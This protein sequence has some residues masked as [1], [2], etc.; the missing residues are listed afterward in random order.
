MGDIC[1]TAMCVLPILWIEHAFVALWSFSAIFFAMVLS[2]CWFL[3]YNRF[4]N[5]KI[6][7]KW[8]HLCEFLLHFFNNILYW[9][10]K[11]TPTI[12]DLIF[13]AMLLCRSNLFIQENIP[14][15]HPQTKWMTC[16]FKSHWNS[17]L[18][19]LRHN[20]N[21]CKSYL[22][23]QRIPDCLLNEAMMCQH[24]NS[25]SSFKYWSVISNGSLLKLY[26]F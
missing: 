1:Q 13:V 26:S 3:L 14:F 10:P 12:L 18:N 17:N 22:F 5:A 8:E 15:I 24:S 20:E 11:E 25:F 2:V 23:C 9:T 4:W 19:V 21:C 16:E 7:T 6:W